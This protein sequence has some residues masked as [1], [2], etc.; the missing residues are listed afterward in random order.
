MGS[1]KEPSL[2]ELTG[3]QLL[4]S[5]QAASR[6]QVSYILSLPSGR[7]HLSSLDLTPILHMNLPCC[8]PGFCQC[9]YPSQCPH[10]T[11]TH[12]GTHFTTRKCGQ[13][14]LLTTPPGLTMSWCPA[15]PGLTAQGESPLPAGSSTSRKIQVPSCERLT[16][17]WLE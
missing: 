1:I 15:V 9:H 14:P 7:D 4:S 2:A 10:I 16:L 12:Q 6:W 5:A 11:V 3:R 17:F 13:R 8:L